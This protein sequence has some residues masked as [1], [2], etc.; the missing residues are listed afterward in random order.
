MLHTDNKGQK[1]IT[2]QIQIMLS[3]LLDIENP[4]I[5]FVRATTFTTRQQFEFS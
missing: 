2:N 1:W 3:F 5:V 4:L